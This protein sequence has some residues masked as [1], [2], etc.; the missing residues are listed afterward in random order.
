MSVAPGLSSHVGAGTKYHVDVRVLSTVFIVAGPNDQKGC[1]GLTA[2]LEAMPVGHSGG[3][4]RAVPGPQRGFPGD[5]AT[6]MGLVAENVR[7]QREAGKPRSGSYRQSPRSASHSQPCGHG[8]R[9]EHFI[10]SQSPVCS[11][12]RK[13][14]R[15]PLTEH[16][17]TAQDAAAAPA[18][19]A[20]CRAL[21]V[22]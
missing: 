22:L 5:L 16:P 14:S 20:A 9:S 19:I 7:D 1:V 21:D 12:Q 15:H 8:S 3:P 6:V 4:S 10:R 17:T 13:G 2:I 11:L 18:T